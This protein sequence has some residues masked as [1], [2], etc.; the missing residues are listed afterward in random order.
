M[1]FIKR[2][3]SSVI[4]IFAL[5]M[6]KKKLLLLYFLIVIFLV[7]MY[8]IPDDR[9][10][11]FFRSITGL[12]CPGCGLTRAGR[13]LLHFEFKQSFEFHPLF[14]PLILILT[15]YSMQLF[16]IDSKKKFI[17]GLMVNKR[18]WMLILCLFL[19]VYAIRMIILYPDSPPMIYDEN[20]LI[21]KISKIF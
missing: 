17:A 10:L 1:F 2:L 8:F 20:C 12:P 7:I 13:H 19:I 6:R 18:F 3:A 15:L 4:E 16:G 5:L 21:Q 9:S 14:V 11:C